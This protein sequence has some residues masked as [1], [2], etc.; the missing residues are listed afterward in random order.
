MAYKIQPAGIFDLGGLQKLE[1]ACFQVDAWPLFDLVAVLTFPDVIRL[2][3][4]S[5]GNLVGFIAGDPRPAE[6]SAWIATLGV[7]PAYQKLGIGRALLE[8]CE[9]QLNYK[10]IRLCVRPANLAALKLYE[11]SG[12]QV[13]DRWTNYYNDKGDALVMEKIRL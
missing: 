7:L 4:V 10:R 13:I 1:R 6:N 11:I 3:A 8:S 12:Y 9:Q 5:D 2:K